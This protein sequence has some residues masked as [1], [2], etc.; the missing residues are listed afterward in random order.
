MSTPTRLSDRLVALWQHLGLGRA[1]VATQIPTDLADF[2]AHH[3][4]RIAGAV[5][6][7][8]VRLDPAPF[9]ALDDRLLMIAGD[10]GL[11]AEATERA[12]ARLPGARR[13]RLADY[14]ALGWSDV[15]ADRTEAVVAALLGHLGDRAA[16][17]PQAVPREGRHAGLTYRIEGSGPALVLLPFFLAPSQWQ[18]ALPSIR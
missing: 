5:L 2:A 9:V 4:A 8:P 11:T 3:A 18:P 15:V 17:A 14:E 10:R 6:C 13:A 1:H 12:A 16:D 7:V